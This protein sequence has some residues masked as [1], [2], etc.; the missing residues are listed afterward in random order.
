MIH[1]WTHPHNFITGH[2]QFMLLENILKMVR[3]AEKDHKIKVLT[4]E[5]YCQFILEA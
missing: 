1:L 2:Q 3:E 4:Q 5:E